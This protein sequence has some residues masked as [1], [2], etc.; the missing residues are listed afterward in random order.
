[1]SVYL[2]IQLIKI[3]KYNSLHFL[4]NAAI[5]KYIKILSEHRA[6]CKKLSM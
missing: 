6:A 2:H 1:M 5:N 3:H 4:I